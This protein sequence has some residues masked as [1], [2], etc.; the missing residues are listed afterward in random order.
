[1]KRNCRR[2]LIQHF[3]LALVFAASHFIMAIFIMLIGMLL[4]FVMARL[5]MIDENNL[6]IKPMLIIGMAC[7]ISGF[8]FSAVLGRVPLR[9]FRKII[10]ATERIANGDYSARIHLRGPLEFDRLNDSFNHMAEELGSVELLRTDFVNNFSHEFKTPIVSIRGFAK[11]LRN[12]DLTDEERAEYLDIIISES[13]RLSALSMNVLR[14]SKLEQQCILTDRKAFNLSE[15]L[16]RTIAVLYEKCDRKHL[17]ID[18]DCAEITYT[19]NA[20]MLDEV[21]INLLDNAIKFSPEYGTIRI[22]IT[23]AAETAVTFSD[24][25]E[26]IPDAQKVRIFDKFYQGDTSHATKGTGLGLAIAK[27]ITELHGGTITVRDNDTAG[28]VFT[29]TLP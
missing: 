19:G 22:R 13:E 5:G 6:S 26:G 25:G 2:R 27:K 10:E 24:E 9:P 23:Q 17:D 21:W 3:G 12:G 18:F 8:L 20:E 4:V 28:T 1:M 15:Q 29:V 11:M 16:R 7:L 14:L